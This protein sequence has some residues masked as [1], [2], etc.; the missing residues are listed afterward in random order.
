MNVPR[1][2]F[3]YKRSR[4][5]E[6]R[7][8]ILLPQIEEIAG[9]NNGYGYRRVTAE[10]KKRGQR[11]NHKRVLRVMREGNLL[12]RKRR[13]RP[14]WRGGQDQPY[15]N[16]LREAKVT[17]TNQ[18][19]VADITFIELPIGFVYLAVIM[20]FYSRKIVG[21]ALSKRADRMLTVKA[22]QMAIERRRPGPGCIH[23]SDRGVQYTSGRYLLALKAAG[24]HISL[25]RKGTPADNALMESFMRTLKYE[26][27]YRWEYNSFEEA[28][29]RLALFIEQVYNESR[30]HSSLGYLSPCEF[31]LKLKEPVQNAT[32]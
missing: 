16:L 13:G 10:L 21:W 30:L 29:Q 20:D 22:L 4:A 25:S 19:W 11:V 2:T 17:G 28:K 14:K 32:F 9:N 15:S 1:S 8:A 5:K 31:E 24:F 27:V 7:D 12:C 26:E 18:A 23:H 3:Y 6:A